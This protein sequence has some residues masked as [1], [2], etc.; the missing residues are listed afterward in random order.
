[1]HSPVNTQNRP[2]PQKALSQIHKTTKN[3][4]CKYQK[5]NVL[6]NTS[7]KVSKRHCKTE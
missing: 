4:A 6:K 2:N 1:M 3:V 7:K 5:T